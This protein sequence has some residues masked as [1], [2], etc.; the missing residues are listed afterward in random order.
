MLDISCSGTPYEIG[1]KHGSEAQTQVKGSLAFYEWVFQTM[2]SME[3]P[4]VRQQAEA[5]ILS[6][7]SNYPRYQKEMQGIADGAGVSYIDILALN[8][9]SEI[10][11]SMFTDPQ[12][13]G[14]KDIDSDGCTSLAWKTSGGK[15]F[16]SQNWDWKPPQLANLIILRVSE[17]GTDRVPFQMITEA[18]IIGKIGF[19]ANGVGCCLNAIRARGVD[20]SR[21][22]IHFGLRTALESPSREAALEKIKAA[23][24]AASAHILIGDQSGAVGLECTHTGFAELVPDSLGRVCHANN[25]VLK[26]AGVD[27]PFWMEDSPKRTARMQ[28]LATAELGQKATL[29]SVMDLFKDEQ[30]FPAAINRKR[31]GVSTSETLFNVVFEL[32]EKKGWVSLGR[33]TDVLEQV[34]LGF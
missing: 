23:G 14:K 11:F 5:F 31:E 9:R 10:A 32:T 1:F 7:S 6:I 8:I 2:S 12:P 26:H 28:E 25:L 33:P 27:E 20:P 34:T 19:N 3:W 13:N 29:Q 15:S 21:M 4:E 30:N 17:P 16:L 24:I 22:P 18:G